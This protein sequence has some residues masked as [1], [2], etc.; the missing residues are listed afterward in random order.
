[1]YVTSYF[2]HALT[3]APFSYIITKGSSSNL[4]DLH[5][6]LKELRLFE[7]V[8]RLWLVEQFLGG[9]GDGQSNYNSY[10]TFLEYL[11]TIRESN[12]NGWRNEIVRVDDEPF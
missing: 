10:Q 4:E 5:R 7:P 6:K 12:P 3:D 11:R 8:D 1:M 2:V 9:Q